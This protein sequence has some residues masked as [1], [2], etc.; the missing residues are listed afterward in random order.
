V[1]TA[2]GAI[3][4]AAELAAGMQR[5]QDDLES[6]F[7]REARMRIDRNPAAVVAHGYP[8][9]G[10]QLDLDARS[11][12]GHRFIHRVV[13]HLCGEMMQAALVGAADIHAGP[14][15][16]RFQPFEN[17][18]IL[19]RVAVGRSRRRGVEKIAHRAN[20]RKGGAGASIIRWVAES[21]ATISWIGR[22]LCLAPGCS[23]R[24]S[25]E[26]L[27]EPSAAVRALR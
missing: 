26:R 27:R 10:C 14:A 16:N 19:G 24:S 1:Q 6:R 8:I 15:A 7:V 4:V 9:A 18:D 20:I 23:G 13:E 5:R 11:V 12:A 25:R 2:R 21:Q 17:L 3:G 22:R